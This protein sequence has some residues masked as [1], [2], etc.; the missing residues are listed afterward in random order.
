[1]S[2]KTYIQNKFIVKLEQAL[3]WVNTQNV[4]K[5]LYFSRS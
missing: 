3:F 2:L 4:F 1:M 5:M